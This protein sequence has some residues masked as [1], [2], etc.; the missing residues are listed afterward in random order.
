MRLDFLAPRRVS[1]R[2]AIVCT[3]AFVCASCGTDGGDHGTGASDAAAVPRSSQ[4]RSQDES[5][6]RAQSQQGQQAQSGAASATCASK[7]APKAGVVVEGRKRFLLGGNLPWVDFGA[8]FGGLSAWNQRGVSGKM[9]AARVKIRALRQSGVRVIRWWMFPRIHGEAITFDASGNPTGLG[10]GVEADVH[11]ALRL[12]HEEDVYLQLTLFSFDNFKPAAMESGV[13]FRGLADV[14]RTP[15]KRMKMVSNVV[16]ALGQIVEKSTYK[17]RMQSWDL[18]NE[19]EW[20]VAGP[21]VGGDEAFDPMHDL[22]TVDHASMLAFLKEMKAALKRANPGSQITVGAAA[23]K[24][25]RAWL[26]V[27]QDFLTFHYYDWVDQWYPAKKPLADWGLPA[28]PV[29]IGEFPP[30]GLNGTVLDRLLKM[31]LDNGYAG[32]FVW[33]DDTGHALSAAHRQTLKAFAETHRCMV[34]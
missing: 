5:Q 23:L 17:A 21:G 1:S 16:S 33:Q 22:E 3:L 19:P 29:V 8:D 13:A 31:W 18:V 6:L 14:V 26:D 15:A 24:W 2:L 34:L 4:P 28:V 30:A 7:P 27:G 9:E 12:A 11:A 10:R 20:A 32:A 25:R